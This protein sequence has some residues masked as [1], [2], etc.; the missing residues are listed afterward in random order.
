[1]SI[2]Q[3]SNKPDQR[4]AG[5]TQ[6]GAV[7]MQSEPGGTQGAGQVAAQ[8]STA[9]PEAIRQ[10]T[11]QV[12][13]ERIRLLGISRSG[14]YEHYDAQ[15]AKGFPIPPGEVAIFNLIKR[16][17]PKLRSYHEIGSGMGTLP[18]MLAH[19]GFAAVGIDRDERRHLSATAILHEISASQPQ[20]ESNCRLIGAPFPDAVVDLDVSDS[21]A[22]LTDF[23]STQ[24][25]LDYVRLCRRLAD[26]RYILV[27]LQRFCAKREGKEEQE[28]LVKEFASYGISARDEVI[29]LGDN[30]YF[31]LFTGNR[32]EPRS[33][34]QV[35]KGAASLPTNT[36]AVATMAD[37]KP[38]TPATMASSELVARTSTE[39]AGRAT[40]E[41]AAPEPK[42]QLELPPMPQK[43]SRKRFG[44]WA[45]V[46]A[47][48]V[49]G[50]PTLLAVVYYG[51]VATDQ[52]LTNFQF[53]VRGPSQAA[54]REGGHTALMGPS[55]MSPDAF[56]VTD[57]INSPQAAEDVQRS[58][59]LRAMFAKPDAD[60]WARLPD[61]FSVEQLNAFWHDIVWARFDLISGNVTVTVRAFSP[62]D[63]LKLAQ[64]I[65]KGANEM[66]QHMNTQAQQDFVRV[67]DRN[68]E[69]S[70]RLL[71]SAREAVAAFRGKS[72][73]VEPD[74]TAQAGSSIVDDMRRQ[75]ATLQSLYAATK[76]S[77]GNSPMLP[78]LAAQIAAL[79]KQIKNQDALGSSS[80]SSVSPEV[81]ARYQ[82]LEVERMAAEKQYT[83]A[84]GLRN[85]AQVTAM[86]QQ[87]Y[88]AL[89]AAPML[90]HASLY[91][92]RIRSIVTVVLAAAAAWFVGMLT[93]YALRDHL[94]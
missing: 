44:G 12:L 82:S 63:S 4:S 24:S 43:A 89:F 22:I 84:L 23:V 1:M 74:K 21:M 32:P 18:L 47:L 52:Y 65:V 62:Q 94:S 25:P 35:S 33:S 86:G 55:A 26:Y 59:D 42:R 8:T 88:L 70:Q 90:A 68:V 54:A 87:S 77:A 27:D 49:I 53:A 15:L 72:G 41:V 34:G 20:I 5:K 71:A 85:Q 37:R 40:T 75:L 31:R 50:I 30:G 57:Y 17:F 67:A 2:D 3:P 29:D 81:L 6:T 7:E 60:F 19:D 9:A 46:S 76:A 91:P 56:V 93:V 69:T 39:V 14:A 79:D 10:Y 73:L 61:D 13:S 78:T 16:N 58:I 28:E 48:L 51:F 66:F 11:V 38:Q 83:D 92:N 36:S 80:V 64:A 45:G